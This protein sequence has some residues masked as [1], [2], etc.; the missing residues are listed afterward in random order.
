MNIILFFIILFFCFYL[1]SNRFQN[2]ETMFLNKLDKYKDIE[3]INYTINNDTIEK[4]KYTA[5]SIF[6][7]DE[8]Y[9]YNYDILDNLINNIE[10][11]F[12][13]KKSVKLIDNNDKSI[14]K[15]FID[16]LLEIRYRCKLHTNNYYKDLNRNKCLIS[17][18]KIKEYNN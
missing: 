11:D 2:N 17:I 9:K 12:Y 15:M 5:L 6:N 14:M 7:N 16:D 3:I 1:I 8:L 4:I 18:N 13:N 10:K